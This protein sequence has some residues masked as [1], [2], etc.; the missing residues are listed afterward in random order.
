MVKKLLL[1][2]GDGDYEYYVEKKLKGNKYYEKYTF[3]NSIGSVSKKLMKKMVATYAK[4]YGSII[5]HAT[6]TQKTHAKK[7]FERIRKL[8]PELLPNEITYEFSKEDASSIQSKN[9]CPLGYKFVASYYTD[10]NRLRIYCER[11]KRRKS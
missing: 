9:T 4:E 10:K 6:L 11:N 7:V 3:D 8:A 1:G 2:A 5:N